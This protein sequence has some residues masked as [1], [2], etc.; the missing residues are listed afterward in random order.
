AWVIWVERSGRY[1]I[2]GRAEGDGADLAPQLR[3]EG[4]QRQL[5]PRLAFRHHRPA[6]TALDLGPERTL[7]NAIRGRNRE[8]DSAEFAHLETGLG[9]ILLCLA[10]GLRR[11]GKLLDG[12][13]VSRPPPR[14][15]A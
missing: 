13:G 15:R 12:L 3:R 7:E 10:H 8:A 5:A 4:G 1:E 14:E 11:G 6:R 2:Q 9:E